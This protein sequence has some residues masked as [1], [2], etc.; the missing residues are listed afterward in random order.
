[1]KYDLIL[2]NKISIGKSKVGGRGI[3]AVDDIEEDEVLEEAHFIVSGAKQTSQD[4]ELSRYF[5][6]IFYSKEHTAEENE[7][8]NF[9]IS[10]ASHIPDKNLQKKILE[11][12]GDLGYKDLSAIYSTAAVLGYGMIYNHSTDNYNATWNLDFADFVFRYTSI[13]N[14]RKGEEIFINY[15]NPERK[16]LK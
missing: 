1:M 2:N 11:D 7:E 13:K 3:F 5:F 15:G 14:I 10:L 8:V 9:K 12:L 6:S 4:K 16:D